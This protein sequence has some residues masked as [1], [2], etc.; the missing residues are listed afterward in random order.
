MN[1]SLW[2]IARLKPFVNGSLKQLE[3]APGI[4]LSSQAIKIKLNN[5]KV[6]FNFI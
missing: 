1:K 6:N 4:R 5:I 2:I 3:R